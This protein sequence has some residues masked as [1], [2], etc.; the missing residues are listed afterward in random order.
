MTSQS[1][2]YL[3]KCGLKLKKYISHDFS[4]ILQMQKNPSICPLWV[5]NFLLCS[6]CSSVPY[7]R[8]QLVCNI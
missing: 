6:L 8:E 5:Q 4:F 1:R 3:K 7:L 2:E